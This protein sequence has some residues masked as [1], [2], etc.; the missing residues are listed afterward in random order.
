VATAKKVILEDDLWLTVTELQRLYTLTD[1]EV[2]Y[3][4]GIVLPISVTRRRRIRDAER[5]ER[6]EAHHPYPPYRA[7][8][9]FFP[10]PEGHYQPGRPWWQS[11]ELLAGW[12]PMDY[13]LTKLPPRAIPRDFQEA[14]QAGIEKDG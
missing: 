6:I 8:A 1:I 4:S 11:F 14:I 3:L 5:P 2:R 7:L 13:G 10:L 9:S 12:F